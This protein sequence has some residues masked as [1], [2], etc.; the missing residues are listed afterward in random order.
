MSTKLTKVCLL[1]FM[2][3]L[4]FVAVSAQAEPIKFARYPHISN[5]KIAFSYFGDI[6]IANENGSNPQRLT[7]HIAR[8]I[9][10]RFS[11][12][13]RWIA[14]SSDRMGNND[15]FVIPVEGGEPRQLT[16]ATTNDDVLYWTPDGKGIRK[17]VV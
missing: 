5:G 13:G 12:D 7:A 15:V 10:P 11:P 2:A 8:D 14:F 6:W 3:V 17:S 16:F 1:G 9:Y 4:F